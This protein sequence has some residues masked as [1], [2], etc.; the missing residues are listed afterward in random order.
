MNLKHIILPSVALAGTATLLLPS[1]SE[2]YSFI[3]GSL[4]TT[5]RD[6]RVYNNFTG[7]AANNNTVPDP[8]FPGYDGAEMAVWKGTVEW[9]STLHGTGNGDPA[10][11]G[12]LGSGGANF[13]AFWAGNATS[14]G[15]TN[16]NIVSFRTVSCGG[17]VLAYTE[18]PISDGWRIFFCPEWSWED[19]PGTA[20]GGWDIQGILTHEYGHALGLGHS[21]V[22]NATMYASASQPAVYERT[23]EAD[24]IAG[25]RALYGLASGTKPR[26]T[27]VS[28]TFGSVTITGQN[29][30]AVDN[31]V[32]FT[33]DLPTS[34]GVDPL[35]VVS[36]VPS[37]GTSI[38]VTPPGNAGSGDVI[39]KIPGG[40]HTTV[41]NAW[42]VDLDC[43]DPTNFCVAA[44]NTY[45]PTGAVISHSGT[46]EIGANNLVLITNGIP[47]NK[48][49]LHLYSQDQSVFL[50]FG[51][52][53]RCLGTPF[54]RI[55]PATIADAFG[56]VT[57]PVDLNNL[58][59]A[60][61]ISA[62]ESWG[63]MAWYRDPAAGGAFFNGSD[64]LSTTW[65]P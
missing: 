21:T 61:Q 19:G 33:S 14:G 52:G 9:G 17:G 2:A 23:I 57:Y 64:A 27:G 6:V 46:T 38:T 1:L 22:G 49:T 13:D 39:V 47:P 4:G 25:I 18:T 5:Q 35:V 20:I 11:P 44:P 29:F 42:P 40:T 59:P 63:F 12:G 16:N 30:A 50:P 45:S 34:S 3:G 37:N 62:G 28:A 26:I 54:Y 51:N 15:T 65:C 32:W 36:F 53:W 10:Q 48:L 24:D 31:Q 56:V 58:P 41:S 7:G 60:G 8:N 55:Y 43:P